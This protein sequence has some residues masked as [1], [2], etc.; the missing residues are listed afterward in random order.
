MNGGRVNE[1]TQ[2]VCDLF[3]SA[4]RVVNI[5]LEIFA[6]NLASQDARVIHVRWNPPAGGNSQLAG[7]LDK[8]RG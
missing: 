7:L 5:G 4:P 8:L 6:A 2:D 1:K 3:A